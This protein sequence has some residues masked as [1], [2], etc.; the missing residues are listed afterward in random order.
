ML[1]G[2]L[3][4]GAYHRED[5]FQSMSDFSLMLHVFVNIMFDFSS[6]HHLFVSIY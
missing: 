6:M 3:A 1:V 5:A 2:I 4:E